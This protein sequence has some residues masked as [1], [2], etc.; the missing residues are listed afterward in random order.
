MRSWKRRHK[1]MEKNLAVKNLAKSG[2]FYLDNVTWANL[3][4]GSIKKERDAWAFAMCVMPKSRRNHG[5]RRK[6]LQCK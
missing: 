4:L 6:F 5:A 2:I 3:D 1:K